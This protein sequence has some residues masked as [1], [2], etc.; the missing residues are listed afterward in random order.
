MFVV[1]SG[2][3]IIFLQ[4]FQCI[5]VAY[6]WDKSISHARCININAL[7]YT[8]AGMSIFQDLIILV[9]P[10]SEL[11]T[12]QLEKKQK[13]ALFLVFQVGALYVAPLLLYTMSADMSNKVHALPR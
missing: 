13:V 12:L 1:L 4:I 10:M 6:N 8:H 7:T 11:A 9:L 3:T 2:V 5:P